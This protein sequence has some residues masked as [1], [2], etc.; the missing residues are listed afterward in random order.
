M[1]GGNPP[2]KYISLIFRTISFV[3]AMLY[4]TVK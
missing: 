2:I 3:D 1:K 4:A